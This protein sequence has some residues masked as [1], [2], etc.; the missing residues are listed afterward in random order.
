MGN[1]EVMVTVAE[2][3]FRKQFNLGGAWGIK[4]YSKKAKTFSMSFGNEFM[5]IGCTVPMEFLEQAVE[6]YEMRKDVEE[7]PEEE[8]PQTE[9]KKPLLRRK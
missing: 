8:A 6:E 9:K 7:E 3:L 1:N 4:E 2:E 5:G